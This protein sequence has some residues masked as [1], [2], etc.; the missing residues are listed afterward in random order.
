MLCCFLFFLLIRGKSISI[1]NDYINQTINGISY[2]LFLE[3]QTAVISSIE[4]NFENLTLPKTVEFQG[5]TFTVNGVDMISTEKWNSELTGSL[6]ISNTIKYIGSNFFSYK[7]I[8]KLL[9]EEN[10]QIEVIGSFYSTAISHVCF[11]QDSRLE[12]IEASAFSH[13]SNIDN[14]LIYQ[15]LL[16]SLVR[17]HFS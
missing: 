15:D 13:C 8:E 11:E 16:K 7:R 12:T 14:L 6:T 2:C 10:S 3:N 1:D 4:Q 9:F 5:K 17:M